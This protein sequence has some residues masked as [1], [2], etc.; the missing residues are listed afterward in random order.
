MSGGRKGIKDELQEE[1]PEGKDRMGRC[2]LEGLPCQLFFMHLTIEGWSEGA[3][4]GLG[5]SWQEL[6]CR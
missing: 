6:R 1:M 2:I 3:R 4:E 5:S